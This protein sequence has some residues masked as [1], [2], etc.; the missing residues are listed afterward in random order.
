MDV[1]FLQDVQS[2]VGKCDIEIPELREISN[3]NFVAC[4]FVEKEKDSVKLWFN[5]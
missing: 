4:H 2:K 5:I 3:N 1:D